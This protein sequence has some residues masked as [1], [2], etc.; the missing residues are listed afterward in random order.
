[1]SSQRGRMSEKAAAGEWEGNGETYRVKHSTNDTSDL[2]RSVHEDS[3]VS[4]GVNRHGPASTTGVEGS[5]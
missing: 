3:N 4:T 5:R 1:M 2:G